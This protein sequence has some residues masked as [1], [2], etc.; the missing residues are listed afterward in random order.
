[1]ICWSTKRFL[2]L[3]PVGFSLARPNNFFM[4]NNESLNENVWLS[5]YYHKYHRQQFDD[6]NAVPGP[7]DLR[8]GV[9][10][11]A[12][13]KRR[14]GYFLPSS[15]DCSIFSIAFIGP[16]EPTTNNPA[17]RVGLAASARHAN[18]WLE[19]WWDG[20]FFNHYCGGSAHCCIFLLW[21]V[22]YFWDGPLLLV[23]LLGSRSAEPPEI[24]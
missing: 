14:I 23:T 13:C 11:E 1:M 5:A 19:G 22:K 16:T 15:L 20:V 8:L 12:F 9:R 2:Q 18:C 17:H 21:K 4:V 24:G 10:Q 6:R 7:S 3:V